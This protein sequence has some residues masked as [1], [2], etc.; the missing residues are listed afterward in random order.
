MS[1]NFATV[2]VHAGGEPDPRTGAVVP[3]ISLATTFAQAG[4][5]ALSGVDDLNSFGKGYEYSRLV[6][7]LKD[8]SSK[9]IVI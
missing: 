1:K 6:Y 4:I 5:G 3:P 7:W 2:C 9:V 8:L